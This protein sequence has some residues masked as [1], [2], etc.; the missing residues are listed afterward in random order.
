MIAVADTGP[1]LY[2]SLIDQVGLLPQIFEK[3]LIPQAV[4]DELSRS[5]TPKPAS[6]LSKGGPSW[7]EICTV[8]SVDASLSRFG[9][10][11]ARQLPWHSLPLPTF[12]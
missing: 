12:S 5:S 2:L 3:V 8:P 9:R 7:L 10:V 6:V 4:A 11:S 1:L